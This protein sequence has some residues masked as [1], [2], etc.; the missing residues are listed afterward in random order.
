MT[1]KKEIHAAN[2][3]IRARFAAAFATMTPERAQRIREAYYKA[4]EGL[5]TLSE[6]LEMADADAGEL[7]N[8]ILLEEHYI[9]RMALDKFDESDLGTFV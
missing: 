4:A 9:A 7:M 3:K 2:E 5:A 6:E 1:N 8:G